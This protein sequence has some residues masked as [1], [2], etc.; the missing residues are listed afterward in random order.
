MSDSGDV[1]TEN[2]SCT[3][4]ICEEIV[5]REDVYTAGWTFIQISEVICGRSLKLL[6]DKD[7]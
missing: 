6:K 4:Q 2:I 3:I 5:L 7:V 1:R